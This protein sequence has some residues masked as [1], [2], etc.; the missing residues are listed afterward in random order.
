MTYKKSKM[1]QIAGACCLVLLLLL[2]QRARAEVIQD[3][4][5]SSTPYGYL[6][7]INFPDFN[8]GLVSATGDNPGR[9]L[10]ANLRLR[11]KENLS[12][13]QI[14]SLQTSQTASWDKSTGVPL[15]SIVFNRSDL[16][17]QQISVAF[18]K[19]VQYEVD[20]APDLRSLFI[21][22]FDK[23]TG[24]KTHEDL[25]LEPS[26]SLPPPKSVSEISSEVPVTTGTP[27]ELIDEAK[28]AM[29]A[30]N[31][32]QAIQIYTK[33]LGMPDSTARKQALELLGVAREK[34]GQLPHAKAQ[35]EAYLKEF[36]QGPDADR[37]RQRLAGIITSG[38]KAQERLKEGRQGI[39]KG[40]AGAVSPKPAPEQP[41]VWVS[42]IFG[43]FS[44][45]YFY[46][47]MR[48]PTAT[49]VARSDVSSNFDASGNWK[50]RDYDIKT[51]FTGSN[52]FSFLTEPADTRVSNLS[53]ELNNKSAGISGKF[54]RQTL[55]SSG[56]LGR[57]DGLYITDNLSDTLAVKAVAGFPVEDSKR[58]PPDPNK[59][60]IGLSADLK[61]QDKKWKS[62]L[63][64]INQQDGAYLDRQAIGGDARYYNELGSFFSLIDY[65]VRFKS[66][67]IAMMTVQRH[68]TKADT[69]NALLDYRNS[70]LLTMGNALQGQTVTSLSA[71]N[72]FFSKSEMEDLAKDRTLV[73]K[74][75]TLGLTHEFSTDKQWNNELSVTQ[76]GSAPASGGVDFVPGTGNTY[77]FTT[78]WTQGNAFVKDDSALASFQY[79][80]ARTGDTY[81]VTL[82]DRIPVTDNFKAS[83]YIKGAY[84][85]GSGITS[86]KETVRPTMRLEYRS[87]AWASLEAEGGV[88]W[89]NDMS[90]TAP[91]ISLESFVMVGYRLS[92]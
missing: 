73:T 77:S 27:G 51:R 25:G 54:G 91:L 83:P 12:E 3:V 75:G 6:V 74:T 40:S 46:D 67:N 13:D 1:A 37:V 26:S 66:V 29:I 60:F 34:N 87:S 59:H 16:E 81:T 22:I 92:F 39:A 24:Q 90:S 33:I 28:K 79:E 56:V 8:M 68:L 36:P 53:L 70:P 31:Y 32:P 57:F 42:N 78:V 17:I 69:V 64:I 65:D 62:N 35:Y 82:N 11:S 52:R 7:R 14:L 10:Q 43:S 55:S 2:P 9:K 45:D 38:Q 85:D 49:T 72:Q 30:G 47:Q 89:V 41:D 4:Q 58:V 84:R 18:S 86:N 19:S 88:E 80:N 15:E 44:Q 23:Q 76:T 50:K 48:L 20:P 5:I 21:R 71:L 61:S 63:F